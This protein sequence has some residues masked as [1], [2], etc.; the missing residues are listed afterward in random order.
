MEDRVPFRWTEKGPSSTFAADV[1]RGEWYYWQL[2]IYTTKNLSSITLSPLTLQGGQVALRAQCLNTEGSTSLGEDV[3]PTQRPNRPG[4]QSF[5]VSAAAGTVKALWIGVELPTTVAP[6]TILQG[7]TTLA[8]EGEG[9]KGTKQVSVV[10]T[11]SSEPPSTDQGFSVLQNYSR[12]AWLNSKYAI[13]DEV[14]A[15]YL[16]LKLASTAGAADAA[17]FSVELLNRRVTIG[18]NGLPAAVTVTRPASAHGVIA[19]RKIELLAQPVTLELLRAGAAIPA[20]VHTPAKVWRKTP[21]TVDW[22]SVF[23]AGPAQVT[24]NGTLHFD[25]YMDFAATFASASASDAQFEVD[26]IQVRVLVIQKGTRVLISLWDSLM[27]GRVP[28]NA[29]LFFGYPPEH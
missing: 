18:A 15:P 2:G 16:P 13:D 19:A 28:K 23:V 10:L 1:R 12:L 8:F 24:V 26:D 4:F 3:S 14:V 21:A 29:A 5:L 9:V 7:N 11:V 25:G 22:S 17:G 27:F 6:G 20:T